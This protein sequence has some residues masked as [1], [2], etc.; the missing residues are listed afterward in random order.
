MNTPAPLAVSS[1]DYLIVGGG[2][3]GL[4][5][6]YHLAH[7][8]R[9]ASQRVLLIEPEAV[10]A[11]DRTW[12]YWAVGPTTFEAIEA[13]QWKQFLLR[14]PGFEQVLA[15]AP[16]RYR[17]V[18][19]ADF[20]AHVQQALAARPAQFTRLTGRVE[21]L[22]EAPDGQG[23]VA[24]LADGQQVR[25]RYIFDSRLPKLERQPDRYRYLEQHFLGWEVETDADAFD[26]DT[27]QFMD[28]LVP[29][30]G[31][32]RFVY[33]LPFTAR[34]ALVE[35]T[36]F[37]PQ[38][39]APDEYRAELR[40]YLAER[41]PGQPYRIVGEES[42][43]I[44]MTDHPLPAQ[45]S[46]HILNLGTRAG[47]AKPS[48]GYTFA[49]IQAHSA[50]LVAALA[51]TGHPPADPTGDQWQFH[52]FDTL[53]LDI[54]QRRGET[55]RDIFAQLFRH[56]PV[57]RILRFLNEETSWLDNL[58]IMNSVSAGPFLRSIG[59]VLRGRP[60]QRAGGEPGA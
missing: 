19:A 48:T 5:L 14:A 11:D 43:S 25:A 8:P 45:V 59:Q 37:S 27:M 12:R 26:P 46:P 10:K 56:N 2:A 30:H 6:A 16:F 47:R 41:L 15:L 58:R 54:M 36:V 52:W 24:T 53:L 35:F 33:S 55:T 40:R 31:Q 9:L 28:F 3:A 32:A 29:Q 39:L 44:P 13:R 17:M 49:R 20:Y 22:S 57:A 60:G 51:T 7:E 23:A 1:Y 21:A 34:R 4:S 50:R 18:R 38:R 42:G